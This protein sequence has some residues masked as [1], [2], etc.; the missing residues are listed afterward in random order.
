M[1]KTL[2]I[3]GLLI[4]MFGFVFI[5]QIHA[6]NIETKSTIKTLI[7]TAKANKETIKGNRKAF[8]EKFE[9]I[10]KYVKQN[11]T[12]EENKK[13]KSIIEKRI[14]TMEELNKSTKTK[15]NSGIQINTGD[16]IAKVTEIYTTFKTEITPYIDP[17]KEDL[18]NAWIDERIKLISTNRNIRATNQ[19]IKTTI[20]TKREEQ[21][22]EK[23]TKKTE[24]ELKIIANET[25]LI[26]EVIKKIDEIYKKIKT[27]VI[28]DALSSAKK[29]L[30]AQISESIN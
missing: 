11:L 30:Q 2:V 5:G 1:K 9:N 14:K 12:K 23:T 27:Q 26:K 10:T 17:A 15:V 6:G 18:F 28:K 19:E 7:E 16:F 24:K 13:A 3:S 8:E 25:K 21:K 22:V 29:T 20:E 4:S